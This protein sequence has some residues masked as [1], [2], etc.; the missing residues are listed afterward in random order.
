MDRETFG[1]G[2]CLLAAAGFATVSILGKLGF[3]GGL[4]SLNM[5]AA[6]FGGAALIAMVALVLSKGRQAF[7]TGRQVLTLMVLGAVGYVGQTW[8]FFMGL[9]RLPASINVLIYRIYPLFVALIDWRLNN[10]LPQRIYWV[11]MLV[12]FAGVF[13]TISPQQAQEVD[14]LAEIHRAYLLFPVGAAVVN[15]FYL[16]LSE[17]PIANVGAYR[18][19]TWIV[20]GTAVSTYVLS[21]I[22]GSFDARS[23]AAQAPVI[24]GLIFLST[25]LPVF[26]LLTGL[27][28]VGPTIATLLTTAE[29]LITIVLAMLFLGERLT[30]I[31]GVGG[32]LLIIAIL[33][34]TVS[35]RSIVKQDGSRIE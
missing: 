16:V 25:I 10:R 19:T 34:M 23:L 18:G 1:K 24:L 22:T 4:E 29:P 15:A 20:A 13:L 2:L 33:M 3:S 26:S 31:Q 5:L 8:L 7:P 21:T 14:A 11:A 27:S 35:R 30:L 32:A 9:D 6:R 28:I 17:G 12:A